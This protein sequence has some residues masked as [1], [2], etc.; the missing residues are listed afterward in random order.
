MLQKVTVAEQDFNGSRNRFTSSG[1]RV[2]L[3][4]LWQASWG[5]NEEYLV[6]SFYSLEGQP[7]SLWKN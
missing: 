1:K 6:S 5:A 3:L 7:A 2:I 4:G